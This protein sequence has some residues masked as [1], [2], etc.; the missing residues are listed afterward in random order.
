MMGRRHYILYLGLVFLLI[1]TVIFVWGGNKKLENNNWKGLTAVAFGTSLTARAQSG[2]TGGYLRY[3]PELTDMEIEN[4]GVGSGALFTRDS[5]RNILNQIRTYNYDEID[6]VLIEGFV[7]DWY[8]NENLGT[9]LD[10]DTVTVCGAMRIAI[11]YILEMN[12]SITVIVIF[13]PIGMEYGDMDTSE[14]SKRY[15]RT[16]YEY[17]EELSKVPGS[18]GIPVIK[19]YSMS[20][21]NSK[22]TQY[23]IDNIHPTDLGAKQT[24]NMIWEELQK[25]KPKEN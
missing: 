16:Q 2:E 25:Y 15:N 20:N 23:F 11:N 1:M 9:Y 6:V 12:P 21:M 22:T 18:M 24:A 19:L 5:E 14:L 4:C 8:Y 17:Y 10:E 3:L 7:N 13:D